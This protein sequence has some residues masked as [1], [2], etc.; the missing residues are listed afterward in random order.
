MKINIAYDNKINEF[1]TEVIIKNMENKSYSGRL[2]VYL[3]EINS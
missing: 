3:T 2:N 1:T